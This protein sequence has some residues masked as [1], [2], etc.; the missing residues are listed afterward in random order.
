MKET[1]KEHPQKL[2]S[3]EWIATALLNLMEE[4][5]YRQINVSELAQRADLARRTFYRH[6]KTIDDVMDFYLDKIN[7]EFISFANANTPPKIELSHAIFLHFTFWEKY[8]SFLSLLKEN[9]L[10][11]RLLQ[12]FV[13]GVQTKM[14]GRVL[15]RKEEYIYFFVTGGQW[16]LLIQW[17]E[18]GAKFTPQEMAEI[19]VGIQEHFRQ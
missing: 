9:D 8:R 18:D 6:F 3:K 7:D 14:S 13:L 10:L 19:G 16:N 17:V 12:K 15:S 1:K 2:A 11:F 4:K 5:P